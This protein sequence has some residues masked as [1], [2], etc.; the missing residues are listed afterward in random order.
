[1]INKEKLKKVLSIQSES[2]KQWRMFAYII[3]EVSAMGLEYYVDNG[4]IYVV[5]GDS[6]KFPC[7]IAHMDTV[8]RITTDLTILEFDGKLT[9]FNTHK[10]TQSGIGGDDKVGI[11]I[12][13]ECLRQVGTIKAAFFRDEEIGCQGSYNANMDFFNDCSYVLQCDRKG[14]TDF[15]TSASGV[16]LSSNNFQKDVKS[17]LDKHKYTTTFGLMTDVMALKESGL[18]VSCA[19][20]SCGYYN[21]HCTNEYVVIDDVDNCL[22]MVLGIM[23]KL[24]DH[25]YKHKHRYQ[26]PSIH[27]YPTSTDWS[28]YG[29]SY[30]NHAYTDWYEEDWVDKSTTRSRE[31]DKLYS[32]SNDYG[33]CECCQELS[34]TLTYSTEFNIEMCGKCSK[35]YSGT[36][37]DWAKYAPRVSANPY[38]GEIPF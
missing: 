14:N 10:M 26:E 21:P 28:R 27:T 38:D 6:N 29:K 3:R 4:N 30:N 32:P 8:H 7:I 24:V 16:Q 37:N 9:G 12:A 13:L 31:V 18:R 20:V 22:Q 5:K 2:N 33:Y 15:I 35:S 23:D 34:Y 1:M 19:N 36:E 11:F 17:L 25:K